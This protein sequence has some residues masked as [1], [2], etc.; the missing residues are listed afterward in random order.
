MSTHNPGRTALYRYFDLAGRLLYVGISDNPRTRWGQHKTTKPW[1]SQVAVREVEWFPMRVQA[2]AA[3]LV[4]IHVEKPIYNLRDTPKMFTKQFDPLPLAQRHCGAAEVAAA[5]GV[6]RQRVQK[7]VARPDF[8]APAAVLTAGRVWESAAVR[9][10][11]R[12]HGRI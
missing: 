1:A 11:G 7:L 12:E 6:N 9:R 2:A 3:E 8:P 5:F 10:W 4:A